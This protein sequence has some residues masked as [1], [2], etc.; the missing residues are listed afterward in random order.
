MANVNVTYEELE[1]SAR[2]LQAGQGDLQSKLADLKSH[3][4]SLTQSGFVT[5]A[6]SGTYNETYAQFTN[7]ANAT[8]SA[9]EHL[10]AYL[11]QAAQTM[12]SADQQL[13]QTFSQG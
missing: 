12:Q 10:S 6:A 4:D 7:G 5:D 13:S 1:N 3:I 11:M 2:Y 9:L 8:I